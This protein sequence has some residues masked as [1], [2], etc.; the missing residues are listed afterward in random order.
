MRRIMCRAKIHRA[1]VTG[2]DLHYEGSITIDQALLEAADLRP[3]EKVLVVNV[4]TGD[5][6]ETYT[7]VGERDSGA[8]QLNGAA[9]RLAQVGDLVI[10]IAFGSFDDAELRADFAPRKVFVDAQN[11]IR[12]VTG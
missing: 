1:T 7:I 5:R 9:A 2:A 4:N 8:I 3:Y 11:R 6:F 12:H 10:I